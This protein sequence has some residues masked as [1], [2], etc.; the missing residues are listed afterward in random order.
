M[1]TATTHGSG[2]RTHMT[3]VWQRAAAALA[4]GFSLA[5]SLISTAQ[6][7]VVA[8]GDLQ[9]SEAYG[10]GGNSGASFQNDFVGSSDTTDQDLSIDGWSLQYASKT[11]AFHNT[12]VLQGSVPA[13]GTFLVQLAAGN[14]N[15]DPLPG[16]DLTA[17]INAFGTGGVFALSNAEGKLA[18]TGAT[19]AEDPAVVDLLGWARPPP[20]RARPPRPPPPTPPPSPAWPPPARTPPTSPPAPPRP[21]RRAPRSRTPVIRATRRIPV[22]RS[23]PSRPRSPRS[24]EPAPPP[25]WRARP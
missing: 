25:S 14:G 2:L 19:C 4:L 16:A 18:C 21:P 9:I 13:G 11:G 23:T 1:S 8:P 3:R 22:S 10:G 17:G 20:S 12:L 7:A 24:R 15:G 6:A 5:P